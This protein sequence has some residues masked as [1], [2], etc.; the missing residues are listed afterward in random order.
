MVC[1]I[2]R[3][4]NTGHLEYA[5]KSGLSEWPMRARW[6]TVVNRNN[7][8]KDDVSRKRESGTVSRDKAVWSIREGYDW[9]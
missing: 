1:G 7:G 8:T 6:P 3:M 5:I 2:L 9:D 4:T